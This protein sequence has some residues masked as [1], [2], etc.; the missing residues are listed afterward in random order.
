MADAKFVAIET[1]TLMELPDD[2]AALGISSGY[3]RHTDNGADKDPRRRG[4]AAARRP[5]TVAG[6]G[7]ER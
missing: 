2:W 6:A 5:R 4:R 1:S 7:A 3:V